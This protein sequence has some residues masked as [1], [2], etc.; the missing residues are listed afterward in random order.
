MCRDLQISGG[1]EKAYL[2]F[3]K[4]RAV[5]Q[6]WIEE[7]A[8]PKRYAASLWPSCDFS[9]NVSGVYMQIYWHLR[10]FVQYKN[11]HPARA[12]EC[13]NRNRSAL[14]LWRYIR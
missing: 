7:G 14:V 11:L 6:N 5:R 9:R 8:P 2:P 13:I 10:E 3:A 1:R 12:E 4:E